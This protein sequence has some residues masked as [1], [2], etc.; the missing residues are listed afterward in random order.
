[1]RKTVLLLMLAVT[2]NVSA[3]KLTIKQQMEIIHR[4]HN[5]EFVY[6]S[7]IETSMPYSG[8]NV[9]GKKLKTALK[10]LFKASGIDYTLKGRYVIL[11]KGKGEKVEKTRKG[12]SSRSFTVS[13][14]VKDESGES[15]INATI[16]DVATGEYTTTNSYGF[17]SMTLGEGTHRLRY[18]F[19]GYEDADE[20]LDLERDCRMDIALKANASLKE[21]VVTGDRNSR[22]LTTQ[23]GRRSLSPSDINTE[24]NLLSSPDL[25]K[26]LQRTSGVSEG[27]ELASGMYVHGGNDDENLFLMD[28]TPIYQINHALGLFSAFNTDMI[29]NVDFYKS[30]FPARYGGRLSSVTDVRTDDGD[31]YHK[32]WSYTI[33]MTGGRFHIEGPITRG[34]TS[35]NIGIRRTW[36]D[37]LTT[38]IIKIASSKE[39][40]LDIGYF[41][42]DI[43]AKITHKFNERT[44][45]YLSIYSGMDK[46]RT[47][48]KEDYSDTS[49]KLT[50]YDHIKGNISWG[51]LNVAANLNHVVTPKLFANFSAVF[52]YN[53][54][55]FKSYEDWQYGSDNIQITHLDHRNSSKIYDT[56]IRA[57]FDFRPNTRNHIRFGGDYTYHIFHPQTQTRHDYSGDSY[58]RIDT[59][60]T[61]N[62]N[63]TN[64][65]EI[66]LYAEDEITLSEKWNA[67][68][69]GHA[70]IFAIEGKTFFSADPR[71]ALKYQASATTSLKLSFTGMT[72]TVHRLGNSYLSMPTDYWVPTTARLHPMRS[73]Q[74]AAGVYNS[75]GNHFALSLEAYYK[76]TNHLLQYTNIKGLT[77]PAGNWDYFVSDGKGLFYGLELDA[78]YKSDK[79]AIDASYTLS[80][81]K[82]KF[83]GQY[84]GWYYDKFDSRHKFNISARYKIGKRS[85]MYA[86]WTCRTGHRFTAPTQY[87]QNPA[88]P[89]YEGYLYYGTMEVYEKPNNIVLPLY[90]RLDLGFNFHKIT[91]RGHE[92][93]W[94]I[95][96]YNAYCHINTLYT[97]LKW[98]EDGTPRLRTRGFVPI[99]PSVSYTIKF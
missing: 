18:S 32:H 56:G 55:I 63:K 48:Q 2:M 22:V 7:A 61:K 77:P 69:G 81:N 92:R 40:K 28:G 42:H 1:M 20:L 85:E 91:K 38:P 35:Y 15:L 57:D 51:N 59:I 44:Q 73:Y 52:T 34:R 84:D 30:G 43:N 14:V 4:E 67:N 96:L 3:Q 82:R 27:I 79:V 21:I 50:D 75:L 46:L 53:Q 94:N 9:K 25:V 12:K 58:E 8:T 19:V 26:N 72:Q 5:V 16:Y 39:D 60:S 62:E 31:M 49:A 76:R 89:G 93:I 88:T 74:V 41:L 86:A 13:G 83:D 17:Y 45:G 97:E 23:T 70:T 71:L 54:A 29:K 11:K 37:L 33:G 24:F 98:R 65:N 64:A 87:I 68:I 95:S 47:D 6:D 90:H 36:L 80:W 66:N 99:I 78:S 10:E